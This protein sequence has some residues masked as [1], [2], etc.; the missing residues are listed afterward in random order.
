VPKLIE[1]E[2]GH[3]VACHLYPQDVEEKWKK[4]SSK[5]INI[6]MTDKQ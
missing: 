1:Y 3:K 6:K 5:K 2:P 4:E